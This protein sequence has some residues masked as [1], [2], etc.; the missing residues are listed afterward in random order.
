MN[1]ELIEFLIISWVVT[2]V[3]SWIKTNLTEQDY[4]ALLM[5]SGILDDYRGAKTLRLSLNDSAKLIDIA[6][7]IAKN[8]QIN[9]V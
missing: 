7:R 8:D 2:G 1:K 4:N 9:C 6:M 3:H 5:Y